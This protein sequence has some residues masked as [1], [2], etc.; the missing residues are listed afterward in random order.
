M[1]RRSSSRLLIAVA[2]VTVVGATL[3]YVALVSPERS[4]A[5][6][7]SQRIETS[8]AEL[9]AALVNDRPGHGS[10]VVQAADVFRLAK[11]MPA[12]LNM[13]DLLLELNSIADASGVSFDSIT[14]GAL[15][16]GAAGYQT[17]PLSLIVQGD[18]RNLASFLQRL[19][20]LVRV[21][22]GVLYASGPVFSVDSLTFGEGEKKFP[23]LQATLSMET[24]VY[25][26]SAASGAPGTAVTAQ[27]PATQP[28]PSG[29][30]AAA[31]STGA[32]G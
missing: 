8:Q 17:Q 31:T 18:Y 4:K 2:V 24:Y 7:L 27:S 16:P 19:R 5:D 12:R 21:R 28:A 1:K 23:Q 9:L 10:R 25:S 14:P 20:N 6:K 30:A 13:P 29:Q 11:A 15:A 26:P 32:S 3:G 22:A